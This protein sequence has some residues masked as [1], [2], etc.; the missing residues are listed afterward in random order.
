MA[1]RALP[2]DGTGDAAPRPPPT[3]EQLLAQQREELQRQDRA[4]DELSGTIAEAHGT[5]AAIGET[6]TLHTRLLDEIA[7]DVEAGTGHVERETSRLDVVRARSDTKT[8]WLTIMALS[9]WFLIML[10]MK[11]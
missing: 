6:A 7:D 11:L 5:A 1:Y 10:L 4:L 3:T 8:L 9:G 2:G